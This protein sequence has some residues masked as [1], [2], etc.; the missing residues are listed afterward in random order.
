[1]PELKHPTGKEATLGQYQSETRFESPA[2]EKLIEF[3]RAPRD[4]TGSCFEDFERVLHEKVCA[5]EREQL[6]AELSRY[7]VSSKRIEVGG[8][9]YRR[10]PEHQQTYLGQAGEFQVCRSLYVPCSGTGRAI[11]PVELRAGI[12]GG[13]WT[14]RAAK[15][16]M[17]AVAQM[18]PRECSEVFSEQGGMQP[19]TSSLDRLPK[20][21]SDSWERKRE[22]FEAE[23]RSTETMPECAVTLAISID[24]V[25]VPMKDEGRSEKRSQKDKRPMGPAGYKEVGCATLS[26]LGLEGERLET[27]R[28]A[29]M[30]QQG[31]EDVKAW[32]LAEAKSIFEST[33]GLEVVFIADGARDLWKFAEELESQLEIDDMHKVLD[34]Y[35]ALERLKQALDAY[36]GE[37][38]A[39][40]SGAFEEL[41]QR[42][43]ED[44]DGVAAVL[45]ALRYRRDRS[46]GQRRQFIDRQ[47]RY[48]EKN[49]ERMGY[50]ELRD[51]DLPI[52]SGIVEA[53]CKTL[54][55]QRL[56]RSGMSWR[57]DGGQA[58]LTARSL[59]QSNRWERGW[60]LLA[61]EFVRPVKAAS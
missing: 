15:I 49:K 57:M 12:I 21:I 20:V 22:A 3:V 24:G 51:R 40:A 25:Q 9:Q 18:T 42:L 6:A 55:T 33:P 41:R 8:V 39:K 29:R 19:S 27:I 32:V 60:K 4:V 5:L 2:L 38:S 59:L 26:L 53:A 10:K 13:Y 47:I 1:M 61:A 31:K 34:A 7:D 43:C 50:A 52:G 17:T 46:R 28:Y 23:L 11:C 58:I 36:H 14:P 48:F 54:A 35:H 30:P 44:P 56:K 45:R 16:A 37:G